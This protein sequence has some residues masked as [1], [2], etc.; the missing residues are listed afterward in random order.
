MAQPMNF[1]IRSI[2]TPGLG[3]VVRIPAEVP[4]ITSIVFIPRAKMNNVVKPNSTLCLVATKASKTASTGAVH[5][6]ITSPA[7]SPIRK[8]PA[9][10]VL[11]CGICLMNA[12]MGILKA[13]S[14]FSPKSRQILPMRN[15][16][17]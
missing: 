16:T 9:N 10:P 14:M 3:N 2:Q 1:L 8:L 6:P 7:A 15:K 11:A 12:G 5:G 17:Y 4:A 13:P